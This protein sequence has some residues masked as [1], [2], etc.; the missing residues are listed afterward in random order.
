[1]LLSHSKVS[2]PSTRNITDKHK[3]IYEAGINNTTTE[4]HS[5]L[6][7]LSA[8]DGILAQQVCSPGVVT[9]VASSCSAFSVVIFLQASRY[10][11]PSTIRFCGYFC[12]ASVTEPFCGFG[13][14][15]AALIFR[16]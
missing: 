7:S 5:H 13:F 4:L 10:L 6:E 1:M 12:N 11:N 3:E 8:W 2:C 15:N 14:I 9:A 16:V